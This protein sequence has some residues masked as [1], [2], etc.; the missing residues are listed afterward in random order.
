MDE[1]TAEPAAPASS[2]PEGNTPVPVRDDE[3]IDEP[4][5]KTDSDAPTN[6]LPPAPANGSSAWQSLT[7]KALYFLSHASNETLGACL[8]GLGAT[9]YLVLGRVGLVIIGIAGGVVLHATWEGIRGDDRD[10][11]TKKAD[12]ERQ[13]ETAVDVARRVLEWRRNEQAEEQVEDTRV[14]ANQALDYS[15]F[16][17]ETSAALD[18]FTNAVIKD[19]VHYWYDATIPGELS[20][21]AAC[22]RT[23]TAFVLSLSGHLERKRPADAFLDFVG[24]A[25]SM[26][27]VFLT[28]LSVALNASPNKPA[29]E[30]VSAY[31]ELKPDSSLSA[32]LNQDS[33]RS[34]MADAAEDILQS[35]LDPK[36][37]NCP[38]VH[39]FLKEVLAQLVL[40]YTVDMCSNP[41]WINDWIV[42]GLEES[43]TTKE[44]MDI[45]DAGVE[46]RPQPEKQS[47]VRQDLEKE[48]TV[49]SKKEAAVGDGSNGIVGTASSHRR[50]VSRAEQN[51]EEDMQ[52]EV[53]KINEMIFEAERQ[54]AAEEE[55]KRRSTPTIAEDSSDGTT[56]GAPTP[57][58]SQSGRDKVEEESLTSMEESTSEDNPTTPNT[59]FTSFDQLVPSSQPTALA[60]SPGRPLP[61]PQSGSLTLHN[62]TISI[63]EDGQPNDRASIK[64]KPVF[65]YLIQIEPSSSVFP[66][67]MIVRKYVDFET[68]HEVLKRI[69]VITGVP[70]NSA[71]AELP[72]WKTNTKASLRTELERYLT[73]AVRFQPLAESEGMKRFLEKDQ[74]LSKSPGGSQ[75]GF[76]WPTPDALGKISGD[77]FNVLT[78][79]PKQVAGGGKAVF[80]GV[81]GFVGAGKKPNTSQTNLTRTTTNTSLDAND[82]SKPRP[83]TSNGQASMTDSYSSSLSAGRASQESLRADTQDQRRGSAFSTT[84]A[85]AKPRPS[86]SPS[87]P[88]SLTTQNG[89]LASDEASPSRS[90]ASLPRKDL[91]LDET[92]NLPPPPSEMPEDYDSPISGRNSIETFRSSTLDQRLSQS[93][94]RDEHPPTPPR[95]QPTQPKAESKPKAPLTEREAA[96][97]VEIMFAV[98]TQ[99]YTLSGAWQ[100]RRT[101]LTAAKTFLLRPGNPQLGSIKDLLQT[102]LF[103]SNLSDGGLAHH[104]LKLRENTLPTAE[105]TEAWKRDFPEKT[106]KQKEELRIKARKLLV[107]KGMPQALT[108]VMGAAAS[109]EALGK[110]F[111]CLQ[112][113]EVSRGLIFGLMLQAL[114]VVTQ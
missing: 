40:G 7:D 52:R 74:G 45:V 5:S 42:Y 67:W 69:A 63:H 108:S 13:R 98:I 47:S 72:K 46:G 41:D 21:P 79:A 9:T 37:Y 53:E 112:I 81:A 66:G 39:I 70:F 57:S 29:E 97:A 113:P 26:I 109:G 93:I 43:E 28:E 87:R 95:P 3:A 114:R 36:S 23:F 107:T 76:G 92:I 17:P 49:Q 83:S 30:A 61:R 56:Q 85:D 105:E 32:M 18:T 90:T 15:K 48:N 84:S 31:L 80:G 102:S 34:K 91:S 106:A 27:I 64:T 24:N 89:H 78:K 55:Q 88:I 60:E 50:T 4:S 71:H 100:I 22:R 51:M 103:E 58:S 86:V 77:M 20:F 44:V 16:G 1:T 10:E 111:D 54:K 19:Y 94:T 110:V 68:L 82:R 73:D 65:D 33:Q 104:I 75:K 62:A 101:L 35:Y 99:L 25:S 96:V 2:Q 6:I 11:A 12:Q 38:P 8:A 59:Q 14:Y